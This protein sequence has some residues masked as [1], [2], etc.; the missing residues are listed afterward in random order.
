MVDLIITLT[1]SAIMGLS[2]YLSL[3]IVLR[4][5]LGDRKIKFL[6]ATAV[7]IL[8]F[9]MADVYS[10]VAPMLSNGSLEG[11]GTSPFFDGVFGA[12]V[13]GGFLVLYFLEHRSKKGLSPVKLALIIAIAMGFQNLTEGL[14]FGAA[15][16][17]YGLVGT[18]L[19][20]LVGFTLQNLTEGFPIA[21][22]LAGK[23]DKRLGALLLMFLIGG[24]PTI[25]GGG[26]GYFYN[27][28]VLDVAFNGVAIGAI[29][30]VILPMFRILF[31]ESDVASQILV[32]ESETVEEMGNKLT[33]ILN[34]RAIY[35]GVFFGFVIGW[36]VNL[37]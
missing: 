26:I 22:P 12:A 14:V 4:K 17:Q 10:D 5:K 28:N 8:V 6:N 15:S 9:L 23:L 3:P 1:L 30:Y 20:I 7:G 35:I 29:L 37:V 24:V 13:A 2:V 32:K 25:L 18:T 36:L 27:S 11:Y 19:V 16:V 21:A 33:H 34:Q 31:R